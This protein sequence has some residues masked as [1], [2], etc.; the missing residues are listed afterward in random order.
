MKKNNMLLSLGIGAALGAGTFY[1]LE[2]PNVFKKAEKKMEKN[3]DKMIDLKKN[4]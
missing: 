1:I 3:I 2:N 4:F